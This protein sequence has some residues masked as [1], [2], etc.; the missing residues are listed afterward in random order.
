MELEIWCDILEEIIQYY[1]VYLVNVYREFMN[2]VESCII[3]DDYGV[4]RILDTIM[5]I[6]Y[7]KLE[8]KEFVS[9]R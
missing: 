1:E 9:Y 8:E 3:V 6:V 7:V 2:V 4:V 5:Q